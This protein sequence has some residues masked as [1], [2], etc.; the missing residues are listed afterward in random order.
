M[1]I[2]IDSRVVEIIHAYMNR[3]SMSV[4]AASTARFVSQ[5]LAD[6]AVALTSSVRSQVDRT[7]TSISTSVA[8]QHKKT[9]GEYIGGDAPYG[10]RLTDG[11]LE[12]VEAEQ[13][14]ITEA[15]KLRAAG[16]SLRA[17]AAMLDER[18]VHSRTGRAF[19]A[20]Q[21]ARMTEPRGTGSPF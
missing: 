19:L 10:Y 11:A 17:I 7:K 5:L 4:N 15:R 3:N 8:M 13:A 2:D 1:K 16:L 6:I 12:A 14:V 9:R 18:G 21:V 20:A